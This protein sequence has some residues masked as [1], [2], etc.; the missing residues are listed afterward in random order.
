MAE[1]L[2]QHSL[3]G[4]PERL[5][6]MS[7][8]LDPSSRFHLQRI[9]VGAG[10]RCLE[11][12]AGNGSLS[13][14][15]ATQ[16]GPDGVAI[17]TD[18]SPDL[19]ANLSAPHLVTR[20]F[21]VVTQEPED[22]PYDLIVIRALLHHLPSRREVVSKLVHWLKPGGWLFIQE[23]DFYPTWTVEPPSQRQFWA[24]F[25]TW[26]ATH[27]IDY[28]VGRKLAP[29]F[30]QEKMAHIEAEGHTIVYN[31]GSE[32]ARWWLAS[33]SEVADALKQEGGITDAVLQEFGTLNQDPAYWTTTIA[34]TAVT[35]QR[36]S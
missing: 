21:D 17:A 23:P 24:D 16:V 32:F 20:A 6:M 29:W 19:L 10:W 13:Q 34:F 35:A 8:L 7:D 27:Q 5:R 30:Q 4:E 3:A 11:I 31:G 28:Y 22:A 33:I 2:W 25:V 36:P 18:I 14:W 9:G 15:L 26:A 12:G 1:Y